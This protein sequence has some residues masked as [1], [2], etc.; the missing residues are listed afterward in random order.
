MPATRGGER[1]AKGGSAV[2]EEASGMGIA[3]EA[4][5]EMRG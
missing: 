5:S 3:R 2:P 4:R 1:V